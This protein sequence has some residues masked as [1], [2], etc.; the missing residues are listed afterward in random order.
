MVHAH[1]FC[2]VDLP[3]LQEEYASFDFDISKTPED[4][5]IIVEQITSHEGFMHRSSLRCMSA[6]R[7]YYLSNIL[8]ENIGIDDD[9]GLEVEG[10]LSLVWD[11]KYRRILYGK[12]EKFTPELLQFWIFHTFF[13]IVLEF[14]KE[15]K[16]LHVG[17]VEVEGLPILFSGPS[18]SGKSTMTDYFLRQGHTLFSDDN[19]PVKEEKGHYVA[20]P[21]FP[22]HRPYREPESLGYRMDNF[23]RKPAVIK[24]MFDLTGVAPDAPIEIKMLKGRERFKS[25]FYSAFIKFP[26]MKKER[27]GFFTKMAMT[28]PVYQV[29]IPWNKERLPEVYEAIIQQTKEL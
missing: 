19:L 28:I 5:T 16:M 21:S 9:W 22:Y 11:E 1:H 14:Q 3:I 20:H 2:F 6:R 4:R 29:S 27:F 7:C 13:P 26:F 10:V 24:V 25:C 12:G 23:A 8:F 18:F 15:Y 17:A